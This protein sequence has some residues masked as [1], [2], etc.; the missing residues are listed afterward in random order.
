MKVQQNR[1]D[2]ICEILKQYRTSLHTVQLRILQRTREDQL[3][4]SAL[5]KVMKMV[6]GAQLNLVEAEGLYQ[7][8]AFLLHGKISPFLVTHKTMTHSLHQ[9]Q[10]IQQYLQQTD[11]RMVLARSDLGHYYT[12]ASFRA[13]QLLTEP[14]N[15]KHLVIVMDIPIT[16]DTLRQS[17]SL[18]RLT[19]LPLPAP[20]DHFYSMFACDLA[21]LG[22]NPDADVLLQLKV[23]QALTQDDVCLVRHTDLAIIDR[24]RETCASALIDAD[25]QQIKQLCRYSL[26]PNPI[27]RGVVTLA[28]NTFLLTNITQ[29]VTLCPNENGATISQQISLNQIQSIHSFNCH[30]HQILADEFRLTTEL[31]NCNDSANISAVMDVKFTANIP[32]LSHFVTSE[33]L[34]NFTADAMFGS[35]A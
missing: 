13:A 1:V 31:S 32:Y 22:Y 4:A 5:Q 20:Q 7:A 16:I 23:G 34:A 29:L 8:M 19:R 21:Y 9:I 14:H 15:E 24:T 2:N 18:Y 11:S 30:C 28:A 17:S 33:T 26:H 12:K 35:F 3:R 25:L 6:A 10:Q 27:P